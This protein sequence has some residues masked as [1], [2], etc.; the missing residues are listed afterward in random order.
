MIR[1][2]EILLNLIGDEFRDCHEVQKVQDGVEVAVEMVKMKIDFVESNA[3]VIVGA[4]IVA[5]AAAEAFAAVSAAVV[6][7]AVI[8]AEYGFD[9]FAGFGVGA[10]VEI[11]VAVAV[12]V[13]AAVVVDD[14]VFVAG[15]ERD[16]VVTA[17]VV[18]SAVDAFASVDSAEDVAF[19]EQNYYCFPYSNQTMDE[20]NILLVHCGL[21]NILSHGEKEASS[22]KW[23]KFVG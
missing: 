17:A 19:G 14:A 16:F 20:C 12:A 5:D 10:E 21:H 22:Y 15:T 9:S 7:A 2:F 13:A 18:D 4:V 3:A 23:K 1:Y 8:T 6:A 11:A